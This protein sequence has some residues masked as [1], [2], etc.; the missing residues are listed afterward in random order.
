MKKAAS[1]SIGAIPILLF[2]MLLLYAFGTPVQ[3][4]NFYNWGYLTPSFVAPVAVGLWLGTT[5]GLKISKRITN[6]SLQF[7]FAALLSILIIKYT[8]EIFVT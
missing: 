5:I 3:T 2:P 4:D 6:Q 1:V 8:L 7:I